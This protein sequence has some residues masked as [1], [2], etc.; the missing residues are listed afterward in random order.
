MNVGAL[1]GRVQ[2]AKARLQRL[3]QAQAEAFRAGA[4]VAALVAE[5]VAVVDAV[6]ID[7]WESGPGGWPGLAL[8]ATGGYGRGELMPHSDIDVLVLAE[9]APQG[10]AAAAIAS[11]SACL[12]DVGLAPGIAVR[13]PAQCHEDAKGEVSVAT[14]LTEA[15]LLAG[16]RALFQALEAAVAPPRVW[17][18]EAFFIAKWEERQARYRR[19]HDTAYNL[20]PN[21]K[22]GPGGLRDIQLVGWVAKRHYGAASLAGLVAA[23]FLD[24][25]EFKALEQA[26]LALWKIRFGLH[27]LA[28]RREDRLVFDYQR[29]LAQLF[30]FR[31][32]HAQNLAV[33]QFM[34]G[35]YRTATT[36]SRLSE[37]LLQG[38]REAI[39]E[40]ESGREPTPI[41][42]YFQARGDYLELIDPDLF[43]RRPEALFELFLVLRSNPR[44]RGVRAS[45][46]RAVEKNLDLI[47]EDFRRNP[48]VNAMFVEL[49]RDPRTLMEPLQ[50]MNRYGVLARYLPVFGRV[51]GR[52]QFDL[53]HVYTVDQHTLFVIR[54]LCR[55]ADPAQAEAFP[56]G[57]ALFQRLRKPELLML[58]GLFHDIAK[59]R[60][61]DHS[62]L[63]EI[64]AREFCERLGLSHGD[65]EL[66]A[67]LVREH[68]LM[69]ITAQ[70][71]DIA[72]PE[73]VNRFASRVGDR[74]RLDC[75]YL[76]TVADISATSPSLWNSWKDRLLIQLYEAAR[77]A[78][79]RGLERPVDRA[80]RIA[81]TQQQ[82]LALL[83]DAGLDAARVQEL[84]RDFPEACFL[85]YGAEQIAWQTQMIAT[86]APGDWPLV[87][88][89]SDASAGAGELFVHM[90]DRDGIFA[91]VTAELD[92]LRLSV[93]QARVLNSRSGMTLDTFHVLE[94]D[95]RSLQGEARSA[96]VVHALRRA[97]KRN[98]L[99]PRP[100][101]R[102]LSRRLK[103]FQMAPCIEFQ[104]SP[105]RG[106]T[107]LSLVCSDRPGLLAAVA[108]AFAESGVR[109]HD[110][111]IATFGERVEDFFQLSDARNQPLDPALRER[112]AAEIR[113]QLA[114]LEQTGA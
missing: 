32:E 67:W 14:T 85:R 108:L 75:L 96:E 39:V 5:R 24:E 42:A 36:V 62:E 15:R 74:L 59:G 35:Y 37:R 61:G 51:V 87:A 31:D 21:V 11:W 26:Q 88:L 13:T 77:Y 100:S 19:Y 40:R 113:R 58:A 3:A 50:R 6:L 81:E 92:R 57:C 82:A 76:L 84:W 104:D 111:R 71:Q 49:L 99:R 29:Q 38:F 34:Q 33:E 110:A 8:V 44:L 30:G 98:P 90:P 78:L 10:P 73:V 101:R 27:L 105:L 47:D 95:G 109:V 86:A 9:D 66:V 28:G 2:A 93:Q 43:Q 106:C 68:L 20:E 91:T 46:I 16:P 12:W 112:L 107:Q 17:P 94:A 79:R 70:R 102:A 63:G 114:P 56:L 80:E 54:N 72:D 53:F 60:G 69:S 1:P 97:L 89:R 48:A 41:D 65:T 18:S 25:A 64:D 4:G 55:F 22:E 52:M 7:L 45:T 23:G 83:A 103:A